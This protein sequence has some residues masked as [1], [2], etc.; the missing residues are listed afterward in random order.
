M[1]LWYVAAGKREVGEK[2]C[3]GRR[4]SLMREMDECGYLSVLLLGLWRVSVRLCVF[5]VVE[6]V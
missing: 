4:W 6:D 1:S 5:D 2:A 3:V